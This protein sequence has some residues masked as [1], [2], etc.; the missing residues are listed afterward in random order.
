[1]CLFACFLQLDHCDLCNVS[2]ILAHKFCAQLLLTSPELKIWVLLTQNDITAEELTKRLDHFWH[3]PKPE[4]TFSAPN[5]PLTEQTRVTVTQH[6]LR[7]P[8]TLPRSLPFSAAFEGIRAQRSHVSGAPLT[9]PWQLGS[10]E[11]ECKDA[12]VSRKTSLGAQMKGSQ[13]IWQSFLHLPLKAVNLK[14]NP[15]YGSNIITEAKITPK[16]PNLYSRWQR[17]ELM[18]LL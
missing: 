1:M 9:S 12:Q 17:A 18:I 13:D 14:S 3:H 10:E 7:D 4:T 5:L 16:S 6:L 15:L 8:K 11:Q 2:P